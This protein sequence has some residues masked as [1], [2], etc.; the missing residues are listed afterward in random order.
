MCGLVGVVNREMTPLNEDRMVEVFNQLLLCNSLRGT[1]GTGILSVDS[2]GDVSILKKA[3]SSYDFLELQAS[4]NI[5][6]KDKV[7]LMGHCRK[8]TIGSNSSSNCHPFTNGNIS[9]FHNGTVNSFRSLNNSKNFS[10][11]S[12]AISYLISKESKPKNAL[13]KIGGAYALVWYDSKSQEMNLARNDE[14]PLFVGNIGDS[15]VYSSEAGL[16]KWIVERNKLTL[17]NLFSLD[18]GKILTIPLDSSKKQRYCNFTIKE[19]N[20]YSFYMTNGNYKTSTNKYDDY[21]GSNSK[22]YSKNIYSKNNNKVD[23]NNLSEEVDILPTEWVPYSE[24]YTIKNTNP[25]GYLKAKC[26]G[27]DYRVSSISKEDSKKYLNKFILVKKT[28]FYKGSGVDSSIQYCNLVGVSY[29]KDKDKQLMVVPNE[30][31][32]IS[33]IVKVIGV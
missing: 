21:F 33:K 8:S 14:R 2:G 12:D 4:K 32:F 29:S 26:Y 9:L 22:N 19:E 13:E 11:D 20:N 28:G 24:K 16:I 5:I 25:Q 7:F 30:D 1:D 3:F 10:V 31:N 15:L 6:A 18:S 23:N 17:D 27:V